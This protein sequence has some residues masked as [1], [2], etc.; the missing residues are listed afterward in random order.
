MATYYVWSGATG[1]D[2][3]GSWTDAYVAFSSAITAASTTG[4][5]IKVHK[6]HL[7]QLAANTTYT[8]L[9]DIAVIVVD[10]DASDALAVMDGTT[11]YIGH[12][13]ASRALTLAGAFRLWV[14]GLYL[15]NGGTS[16][17]DITIG[18]TENAYYVMEQCTLHLGTS[19]SS[20][21]ITFGG[22]TVANNGYTMM[23]GGAVRFGN[24]LQGI[25]VG[26]RVILDGVSVNSAGS[27]P[28]TLIKASIGSADRL[29][30]L[31]CDLA[32]VTGTLVAGQ[33]NGEFSVVFTN[34][35]FGAGVA[36][37]PAATVHANQ[38]IF[39][40]NCSE[41]DTHY[42]MMHF[43]SLGQTVVDTG[44]YANDN[45][46]Y[47]G[48]N[49]CSWKISTTSYATFWTPYVSPFLYKYNAGGSAITPSLEILLDGSATALT[50]A[51]IWGEW[52]Y[53][54]NAA[55]VMQALVDDHQSVADFV[56]GATAPDQ[57]TGVGL[58]GWTG[59]SATAWSGK[60]APASSITPQ[61][62]G[63]L[64]ARVC[65][66]KPSITVYVDPQMRV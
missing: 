7:E 53:S 30:V 42:Q 59:E 62:I 18:A 38:E 19:A 48:T 3:G 8:L 5:I 66:A 52:S 23:V 2:T 47:D 49:K 11:G 9:A 36:V 41:G 43:N 4:D 45:P 46:T 21:S 24:T 60:L 22:S 25:A 29:Y 51:E 10:K 40:Y 27:R 13:T 6:T 50:S 20:S 26:N 56:A 14:Y 44:I 54:A 17:A 57:T 65:V 12:D 15:R 39:V 37:T 28:S 32:Y 61:N 55:N 35:L 63:H 16:A 34:C 31:N 33:G 58:S 1:A 64:G